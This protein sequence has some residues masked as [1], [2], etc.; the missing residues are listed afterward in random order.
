MS[1]RNYKFGSEKLK[2]KRKIE[3]LIESKKWSL[4]KFV[5]RNKQYT[6]KGGENLTNEQKN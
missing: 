6:T 4:N 3:K 1:N 2:K 5:T